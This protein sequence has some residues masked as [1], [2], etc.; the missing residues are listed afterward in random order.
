MNVRQDVHAKAIQQLWDRGI[1]TAKEIRKRTGIPRSTIYYNISKLKKNGSITHRK[2]SGRPPKISSESSKMLVREVKKNPA[3]SSKAL[4][5][6]LLKKEVQV[7]HVTV[8]N[9]L[10]QLG[11]KKNRAVVTPMLTK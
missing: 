10:S 7:S 6:K 9:H 2:R 4:A 11:Y 3:I 5:T 1:Q 8:W